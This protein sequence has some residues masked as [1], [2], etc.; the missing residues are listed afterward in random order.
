MRETHFDVEVDE[1]ENDTVWFV[2]LSILYV[3]GN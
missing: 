1:D 3:G 2:K